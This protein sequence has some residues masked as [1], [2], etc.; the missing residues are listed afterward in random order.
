MAQIL[1]PYCN[2]AHDHL[3]NISSLHPIL[4]HPAYSP[5]TQKMFPTLQA[6]YC[7]SRSKAYGWSIHSLKRDC[8]SVH[9]HYP[10]H[11]SSNER[12]NV[13]P[14]YLAMRH[15]RLCVACPPSSQNLG[16]IFGTLSPSGWLLQHLSFVKAFQIPQTSSWF[17]ADP[18][19]WHPAWAHT[20]AVT[21]EHLSSCSHTASPGL[22]LK[23]TRTEVKP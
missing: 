22:L 9:L 2:Y 19:F 13:L 1:I 23:S 14:G 21:S 17:T 11:T 16:S 15:R 6:L 7:H 20:R 5:E 10:H 18:R 12:C 3:R 4:S 8:V